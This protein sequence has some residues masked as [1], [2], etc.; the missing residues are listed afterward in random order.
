MITKDKAEFVKFY[1][2]MTVHNIVFLKGICKTWKLNLDYYN[3]SV[4]AIRQTI[5][6]EP[7]RIWYFVLK[8]NF[9]IL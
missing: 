3:Q 4:N 2:A 7:K 8:N 6:I 9:A 5:N 1:A